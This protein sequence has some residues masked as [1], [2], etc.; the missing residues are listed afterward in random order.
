MP[1]RKKIRDTAHRVYGVGRPV[2]NALLSSISTDMI[3]QDG[4]CVKSDLSQESTSGKKSVTGTE[5]IL[6]ADSVDSNGNTLTEQQAKLK[7]NKNPTSNPDIRSSRAGSEEILYDSE[8]EKAQY[9][10]DSLSTSNAD[11]FINKIIKSGCFMQ[12]LKFLSV[13]AT[14]TVTFA[15]DIF[16]DTATCVIRHRTTAFIE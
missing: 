6:Y 2:G 12:P 1:L 8:A 10:A 5:D 4:D 11:K 3:A 15:V 14:A 13:I 9:V 7:S 16:A